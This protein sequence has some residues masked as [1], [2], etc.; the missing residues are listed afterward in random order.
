MAGR[1]NTA[2]GARLPIVFRLS[3]SIPRDVSAK[4]FGAALKAA[5]E[6]AG[7]TQWELAEAADLHRTYPSMLERGK[8]T[9][10]ISVVLRLAQVLG[11]D[12]G[13]LLKA[14]GAIRATDARLQDG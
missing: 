9:P 5:R 3:P 13:D 8:R 7:I 12:A 2:R 14:A 1:K 11:I 10:T 4:V 6:A